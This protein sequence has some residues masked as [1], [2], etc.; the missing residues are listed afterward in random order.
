MRN[1]MKLYLVKV[2]PEDNGI[3]YIDH[4]INIP[5]HPTLEENTEELIKLLEP[6][7]HD[8]QSIIL[9]REDLI[10][11]IDLFETP[12]FTQKELLNKIRRRLRQAFD[13]QRIKFNPRTLVAFDKSFII[14]KRSFG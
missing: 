9:Q 2:I 8:T 3:S 12:E 14:H 7:I 13:V 6:L 5:H 1:F 10:R 11:F 4:W